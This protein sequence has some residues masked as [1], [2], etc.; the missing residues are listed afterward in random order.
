MEDR[1]DLRRSKPSDVGSRVN[2]IRGRLLRSASAMAK[3][4]REVANP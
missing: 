1:C 2:A 4:N 3:K